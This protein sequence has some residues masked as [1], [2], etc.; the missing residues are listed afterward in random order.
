M[1]WR[2]SD[3]AHGVRMSDPAHGVPMSDPVHGAH[4]SGHESAPARELTDITLRPL[5]IG[6]A[7]LAVIVVLLVMLASSLFPQRSLDKLMPSPF[8]SA[9]HPQLQ[10]D[11]VLDMDHFRAEQMRALDN[12]GWVDHAHGIA[13]VPI[14]QAMQQV[15]HDGVPG[16]PVPKSSGSNSTG[17][18]NTGL[19]GAGL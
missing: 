18:K 17:P 10:A 6:A 19:K 5:L 7:V 8:P 2:M 15:A 12:F 4:L 16:W 3:P 11:P 13:H 9:P 1:E 14:A